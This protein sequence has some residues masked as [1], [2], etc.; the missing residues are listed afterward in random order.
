M[1]K[2]IAC[3]EWIWRNVFDIGVSSTSLEEIEKHLKRKKREGVETENVCNAEGL[4]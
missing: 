1:V 3:V 4:Q 2:S